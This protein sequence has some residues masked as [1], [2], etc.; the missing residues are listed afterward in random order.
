MSKRM[1]LPIRV[2]KEE[3]EALRKNSVEF[4]FDSVSEYLRFL[5]LNCKRIAIEVEAKK[6]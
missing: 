4:G 6:K 5:G 3:K 1:I 2:S